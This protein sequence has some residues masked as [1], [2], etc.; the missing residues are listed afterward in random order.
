M[1]SVGFK[2][3]LDEKV[4]VEKTGFSG[5]ITMCAIQGD[6]EQ[7]ENVYYILGNT[8]EGWYAERLLKEAE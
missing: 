6:P 3:N 4:V 2:F 5:V 1:K 8:A 7:P